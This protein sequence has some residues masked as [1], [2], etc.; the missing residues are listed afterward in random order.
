ME[1]RLAYRDDA[2]HH[3]TITAGVCATAPG[4]V[5]VSARSAA[6]Y[7]I[8]VGQVITPRGGR[9]GLTVAGLYQPADAVDPYWGAGGYFAAGPA[10]G[11]SGRARIDAVFVAD[12]DE[13]TLPGVLPSVH[14]DYPLRTASIG[15]DD[16]APLQAEVE[17]FHTAVNAARLQLATSLPDVLTDID[18]EASSLGRTIPIVAVPLALVC[19]FVLFLLVAALTDER[20]PEVALAKLRGYSARQSGRFGRAE[21]LW[22]VGLA[23]PLGVALGLSIVELVAR[24]VLGGGVRVELRWPVLVAAVIGVVAAYLAVRAAGS[25]TLARPALALLRRVPER[26]GWRA[27]LAEGIVVAVAAASLVAALADRTMPL[28]LLAPA[29]IAL[30][31]GV[32]T[33]RLL[34]LWSRARLRGLARRG[35][36]GG[37]LAHAQLARRPIGHRIM[38]VVTMAVALLSF[39]ATAW[40][41]AAQART[42]VAADTVGADRVVRVIAAD[43]GALVAAV[44][45]ADHDGSAMPVVR[46]SEPYAG[47]DV[48]LLGVQSDRLAQVAVW[49]GHPTGQVSRLAGMLRPDVVAP[50]AIQGFVAVD[51]TVGPLTGGPHLAAVVLVPGHPAR[52]VDLG[53]LDADRDHY[54]A[55]VAGCG[56]GCQLLGLAVTRP[57]PGTGELAAQLNVTA[58]RSASG[59]VAANFTAGGRWRGAPSLPADTQVTVQAGAALSVQVRSTDPGDVTIEYVDT[60][61]ALPVVVA[62]ATPADDS[63][64]VNFTFPALGEAPQQFTVVDREVSLPRAG[65]RALLFD[66]DYAVRAAERGSSLSDNSRL[67]YE[68]WADP[69]APADLPARLA[70]AGLQVLDVQSRAAEQDQLGRAAPALGL[71]LYLIAGAAAVLLAVGAVLLTA[72]IGAGARRYE[73]AALRVTGVR[74]RT[75]RWALLREYLLLIGLPFLAGLVAGFAGAA[76]MLP[77]IPLVSVG[78]AVGSVRYSPG[79]G[80]LPIAVAITLVGLAF[81]VVAVLRLVRSATPDLLRDGDGGVA[82]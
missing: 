69:S 78:S 73:L 30:V 77:G 64:A 72:Y 47:R 50:L 11:D 68:V 13:L 67:R 19:W 18:T 31:A 82:R 8:T 6:Q 15:L 43:P 25:R 71:R 14:L 4:S 65:D 22:L 29:L 58:V 42:D 26:T 38:L 37:L 1:A 24:T 66:L 46:V 28:A 12:E 62:G 54:R 79:V 48:E 44:D 45:A 53:A 74:A 55:D 61:A 32:V 9:Q 59:P 35:R 41:V 56:S 3:L 52:T 80:V 33:A 40:D 21:A 75:L 17:N 27:G 39:A 16:V 51:A 23:T 63:G 5:V 7:G 49:R 60:P 36:I 81:A 57:A 34:G 10:G 20:A 76:L 70:A 2:C